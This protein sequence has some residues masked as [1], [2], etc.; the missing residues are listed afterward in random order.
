VVVDLVERLH[1]QSV[2]A[3]ALPEQYRPYLRKTHPS[4]QGNRLIADLL[5]DAL[6]A[7]PAV[8]AKPE[9]LGLLPRSAGR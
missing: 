4:P 9:V 2:A 8:Q 3:S 1:A 5:L 7:S 6:R